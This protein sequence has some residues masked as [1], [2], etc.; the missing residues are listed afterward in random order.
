M[1]NYKKFAKT[2]YNLKDSAEYS[3]T[4]NY[5]M[6]EEKF[7]TIDWVTGKNEN[8]TAITT[9]TN[10]HTELTWEKVNTEMVRLQTEYDAQE[11]ARNRQ[12]EY[13]SIGE[14][15]VALYDT[16]DKSAIETKRAEVKAKYPKP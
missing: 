6:T 3:F 12:R 2:L 15:V 5:P 16:D 9:K 7:I 13:P 10:P 4:G 14:L 8:G 11:Y 1:E